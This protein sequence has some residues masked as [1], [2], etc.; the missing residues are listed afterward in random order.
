MRFL[1]DENFPGLAVAALRSAGHDVLWICEASP[2]SSDQQVLQTASEERRILLTFDKDFGESAFRVGVSM[3]SGIILFRL[4][5]PPASRV[6][7]MLASRI[8]ERRDWEGHFSVVESG[9]VRMRKLTA[10]S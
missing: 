2:G 6:G 9:R 4:P 5:T 7:S 10:P 1:A 3:S 8:A